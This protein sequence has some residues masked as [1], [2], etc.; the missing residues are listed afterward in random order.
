MSTMSLNHQKYY[1][2]KQATPKLTCFYCKSEQFVETELGYVCLHCGTVDEDVTYQNDDRE[3]M[4][5]RKGKKTIFTHTSHK[6]TQIGRWY[7]RDHKWNW[8]YRVDYNQEQKIQDDLFTLKGIF[9]LSLYEFQQW[10]YKIAHFD[11]I[12][13]VK[14]AYYSLFLYQ[15]MYQRYSLPEIIDKFNKTGRSCTFRR[16]SK[17]CKRLNITLPRRNYLQ[18]Y[19]TM[20]LN[21]F[22]ELKGLKM[23]L[24][25]P[26]YVKDGKSFTMTDR[27]RIISSLA[28]ILN[29]EL[30]W[31]IYKSSKYFNVSYSILYEHTRKYRQGELL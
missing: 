20:V 26:N 29:R 3:G 8:L 28:L 16:V 19:K 13:Q 31:S 11:I 17:I 1:Q 4:I 9:D 12:Y 2:F 22:P 15:I 21:H 24:I 6:M 27:F 14:Y 25:S 30:N 5:Q 10:K 7:E 18:Y 23:K